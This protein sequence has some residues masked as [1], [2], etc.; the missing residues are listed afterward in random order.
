[1]KKIIYWVSSLVCVVLA[2]EVLSTV[3]NPK[4]FSI[5]LRGFLVGGF[6][7]C[8]LV[9]AAYASGKTCYRIC[10]VCGIGIKQGAG[11]L[12]IVL[13]D[14]TQKDYC[15]VCKQNIVVDSTTMWRV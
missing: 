1:M 6:S 3:L 5:V 4:D 12:H 15:G 2:F 13:K 7:V 9:L 8:S 11:N 14:S 10:D